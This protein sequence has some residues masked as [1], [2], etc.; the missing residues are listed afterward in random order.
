[1]K[2]KWTHFLISIPVIIGGSF[3]AFFIT[4]VNSFMNTPAGF[5]MSKGKMINVEP[6]V[7]MFNDSFFVRSFHVVATAFMT[8]VFVLAAIAAFKLMKNKFKKDAEYHKKALKLTM[9]LG[10]VFTL[11]SMLAGDLS[12]KFLHQEQPEKLAAYEWHFDTESNANLV[13]FG[14]LDEETQE[15]SGA[16]KLPSILSFLADNNVNTEVKG[17]NDFPE[18]LHPPMIVHYY[19]DLMVSMGVFCLIISAAFI[20][21]LCFKKLRR[22]T[23][24]KPML[25]GALLTGP[26]AMLAIEFGWFLTE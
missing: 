19:F 12:A 13:L 11:G 7:A 8:I 15:V 26:A 1:F 4:A 21:T 22:F 25:Y 10:I 18:E 20:L 17:L 23:Y 5:E 6:W 9:I 16:I 3:S 24:S 14:T 2:S